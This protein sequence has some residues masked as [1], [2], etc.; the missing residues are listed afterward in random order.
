MVKT[1]HT[2]EDLLD[3]TYGGMFGR[4]VAKDAAVLTSTIG[5]YNAIFGAQAFAQVAY[6]QNALGILK[7]DPWK[8][9]GYRAVT[10]AAATSGGGISEGGGIPTTVKP[11]YAEVTIA[12]KE[13]VTSFDMSTRQLF[14]EGKDDTLAWESH[15]EQ[16]MLTHNNLINRAL[17][18][19]ADTVAGDN[20]E[21]LDRVIGSE[22]EAN[23]SGY[24]TGDHDPWTE[25]VSGIDRD[26]AGLFDSYVSHGSTTDRYFALTHPDE[27]IQ[28]CA[29][30]W[31]NGVEN[32]VFLT[33]Y[34][35]LMRWSQAMQPLQRLDVMR[36]EIGMNGVKALGNT[37]AGIIVNAYNGIPIIASENVQQDT[38]SRIMLIDNDS[39]SF[40]TAVPTKYLQ[41]EDYQAIDKFVRE[42]VYYTAGE[43]WCRV[44]PA[45]GKA[46]DLK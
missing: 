33:G 19:D 13:H 17:L 29:P 18:G 1:I 46:R 42:A 41:S 24:T 28:N 43:L 9:S 14:L 16:M 6:S 27:L 4:R 3:A 11:T 31:K 26:S 37:D 15:R 23:G 30:Y 44:F 39:M 10:E 7:K 8:T 22:G 20:I 36:A 25:A 2:M 45:Q 12:P 21:S 34:D 40:E 35:T 32:K 5:V 38:I